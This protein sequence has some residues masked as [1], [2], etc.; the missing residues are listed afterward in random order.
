MVPGEHVLNR[1]SNTVEA[2]MQNASI[3]RIFEI[4][5][6]AN[7][8]GDVLM[9]PNPYRGSSGD[10]ASGD[11][12]DPARNR[13]YFENITPTTRI[14][15]HT[16]SGELVTT[17]ENPSAANRSLEWDLTNSRGARVASGVYIVLMTD[18][19][20]NRYMGRLTVIR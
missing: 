18:N 8:L 3:Y 10:R 14:R 11:D 5:P 7:D 4:R 12:N 15:I 1:E 6:F 17:L 16:I 19:D 20:G 9:Y 2:V 13:V